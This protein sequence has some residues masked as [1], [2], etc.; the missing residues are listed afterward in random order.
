MLHDVD[1]RGR[2]AF[3]QSN[4]FMRRPF[5]L[6]VEFARRD[7]DRQLAHMAVEA[8]FGTA[9]EAIEPAIELGEFR[10]VEQ[11]AAGA[12]Q[13]GKRAARGR[14]ELV[15][16]FLPGGIEIFTLHRRQAIAESA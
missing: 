16:G 2:H 13:A 5:E 6:A 12:T 10:A 15:V 4:A 1:C 9:Q 14:A 7:E 3:F 11:D 8:G